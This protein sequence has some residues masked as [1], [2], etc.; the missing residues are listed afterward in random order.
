MSPAAPEKPDRWA[1]L[2]QAA[3]VIALAGVIA[4]ATVN[5]ALRDPFE[6]ALGAKA[7][8]SGPGPATSLGFDLIFWLP[9]ILILF[10]RVLDRTYVLRKS[11]AVIP[12]ILLGICMML[13]VN[14]AVGDRFATIITASQFLSAGVL[15][16]AGT[17]LVRS[18][19]RLR[20]VASVC[21]ALLLTY[22][23]VGVMWQTLDVPEMR[24][25]WREHGDEEL[26]TRGWEPDSFLAKQFERKLLSGEMF[27]F[28]VS[29]NTFAAMLTLTSLVGLGIAIQH[30]SHKD[31]PGWAVVPLIV[32]ASGVGVMLSTSSRTGLAT[33][34]LGCIT[35]G[36][37]AILRRRARPENPERHARN[38]YLVGAGAFLT[39]VAMVV[40]HGMYY[41][42]L[43]HD[44]LTFRWKYWV[45]AWRV[46]EQVPILGTGWSN[47]SW[48]Y[49]G[50]RLP[51]ASEEIKDPHSL[52]VRFAT[53]L[54]LI[55][56]TLAM[57]FLARLWWE[58]TRPYEPARSTPNTNNRDSPGYSRAETGTVPVIPIDDRHLRPRGGGFS[59]AQAGRPLLL[60]A[61]ITGIGWAIALLA[62]VDWTTVGS[63]LEVLKRLL[64]LGTI[65]LGLSI[66]AL[67][68]RQ[69]IVLDDRPGPWVLIAL[70]VAVGMFLI[71]N[72]IDFPLF[73]PGPMGLF[74][75][76]CGSALGARYKAG[77]MHRKQTKWVIP[78]FA[79]AA[80]AWLAIAAFLFIPIASTEA[81]GRRA[82]ALLRAND[83]RGALAL[84]ADMA[85]ARPDNPDYAYRAARAAIFTEMVE[86][87]SMAGDIRLWLARA[88]E[89]NPMS[90][91]A[92]LTAAQFELAQASPNIHQAIELYSQCVRLN[93]NDVS[94]RLDYADVL[95]KAG[96]ATRAIEHYREAL[97][98]DSLLDKNEP[99]RL[100]QEK[101]AA[102]STKI[103]ALGG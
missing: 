62:A 48:P 20:L 6:T 94:I 100:S 29:P 12:F 89:A 21:V 43:V 17:Q 24:T 8:A 83:P 11:L 33:F 58:L 102:I 19:V 56:L 2:T 63:E 1:P 41:G 75:L 28:F 50:V 32:V 45:G 95:A 82:D 86:H 44:S 18:W 92:R 5:D 98:R 96:E 7:A 55:G 27:G 57:L 37:V 16:W 66:A 49:L 46:F 73:E 31:P 25:Y 26:R 103:I 79:C 93:P 10:R 38:M 70:I 54:G 71:H 9:A 34:V 47:F 72:L 30:F 22:V 3:F 99:K 87:R 40:G 84:L 52:L 78:A 68:E 80:V 81:K 69:R 64:F 65:F 4:R 53:E 90:I 76:L 23:A 67:F 42:S 97:H 13:S 39:I 15:M 36:A 61:M 59:S 101:I 74:A 14:W 88:L 60:L 85:R 91:D 35:L 77:T 51:E